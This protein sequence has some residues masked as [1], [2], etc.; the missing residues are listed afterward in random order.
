MAKRTR[1]APRQ[2]AASFLPDPLTLETARAAA[3]SCRGCDLWKNATQTVFGEGSRRAKV[4]EAWQHLM[5]R[6]QLPGPIAT[7]YVDFATEIN[8]WRAGVGTGVVMAGPSSSDAGTYEVQQ[9][10][11]LLRYDN[12]HVERFRFTQESDTV[13]W[14]DSTPFMRT[15]G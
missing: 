7:G 13:I 5:A 6:P 3:K 2:T 15:G 11:L 12:G 9:G 8:S 14:L 1:T 4:V 10:H